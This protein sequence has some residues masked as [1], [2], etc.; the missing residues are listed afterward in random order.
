MCV[1]LVFVDVC[2][3]FY[4]GALVNLES[5]KVSFRGSGRADTKSVASLRPFERCM[6]PRLHVDAEN[7][8]GNE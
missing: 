2:V 3:H 4:A 7:M 8:R 5:V 1:H 6:N